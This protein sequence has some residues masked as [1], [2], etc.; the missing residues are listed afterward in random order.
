MD[1]GRATLCLGRNLVVFELKICRMGW[2]YYR[3]NVGLIPAN[4]ELIPQSGLSEVTE[5]R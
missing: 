2:G 5:L 1:R 4:L 3:I